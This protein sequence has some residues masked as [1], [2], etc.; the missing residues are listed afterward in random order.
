MAYRDTFGARLSVLVEFFER[1]DLQHP[2]PVTF[3]QAPSFFAIASRVAPAF[4]SSLRS[5]PYFTPAK[6]SCSSASTTQ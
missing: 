2:N 6:M 5:L 1:A 3:A 4:R